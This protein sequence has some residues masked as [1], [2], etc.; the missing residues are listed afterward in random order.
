MRLMRLIKF[1]ERLCRPVGHP[2]HSCRVCRT[3]A[4]SCV[5]LLDL[6]WHRSFEAVPLE[7]FEQPAILARVEG[8]IEVTEAL[9]GPIRDGHL[10][11]RIAELE[12]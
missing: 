2:G 9:F 11:V 4:G 6:G 1:V 5:R 3:S 12:R 7:L 10:G 8:A